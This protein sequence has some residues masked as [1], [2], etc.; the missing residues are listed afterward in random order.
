MSWRAGV[1]SSDG[2]DAKLGS[3]LT[4]TPAFGL[5]AEQFGRRAEVT[6]SA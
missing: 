2:A 1:S 4:P 5:R 6:A 3:F